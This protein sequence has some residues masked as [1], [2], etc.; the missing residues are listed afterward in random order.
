MR[1]AGNDLRT[2]VAAARIDTVGGVPFPFRLEAADGP[3]GAESETAGG[4]TVPAAAE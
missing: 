1:P 3:A 4:Q 2:G